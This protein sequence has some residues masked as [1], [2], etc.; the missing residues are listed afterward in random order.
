MKPYVPVDNVLVAASSLGGTMAYAGIAQ[1]D[2]AE[3]SLSVYAGRRVPVVVHE[4]L[5]DYRKFRLSSRPV[6]V[7]MNLASVVALG[8]P[9]KFNPWRKLNHV[10]SCNTSI[11]ARPLRHSRSVR[12]RPLGNRC[13]P[14]QSRL[15]RLA[16]RMRALG[17]RG[18][19]WQALAHCRRI[20]SDRIRNPARQ[21]VD[22]AAAIS[23]GSVTASVARAGSF[24]GPALIV[25]AGTDEAALAK[26]LRTDRHLRRRPDHSGNLDGRRGFRRRTR[27]PR[28]AA[29]RGQGPDKTFRDELADPSPFSALVGFAWR[30]VSGGR[31]VCRG[32]L[33]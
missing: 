21:G 10:K 5:E 7:P 15:W 23:G 4:A 19:C 14:T 22:T 18:R 31:R 16:S 3:S 1:V 27:T 9:L 25:G 12:H 11:L 24:R 28:R 13:S 30:G 17:C 8:R 32:I 26:Q 6:P 29:F 33:T 20:R 2:A